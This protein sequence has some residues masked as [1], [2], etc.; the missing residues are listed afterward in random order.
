MKQKLIDANKLNV[1]YVKASTATN[2]MLC[3][4][5]KEQVENAPTVEAIPI[6]WI[7]K[8]M[9]EIN[10]AM[11]HLYVEGCFYPKDDDYEERKNI[12]LRQLAEIKLH[13][14]AYDLVLNEWRVEKENETGRHR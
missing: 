2:T 4:I 3:Y 13:G 5:S 1:D 9:K 14:S 6:E 12:L 7:E 8:R 10:E 11:T